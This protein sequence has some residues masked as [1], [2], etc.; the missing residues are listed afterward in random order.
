MWRGGYFPGERLYGIWY[1]LYAMKK[2][3][4][5]IPPL[6]QVNSPYP[7][8]TYLMGFLKQRGYPAENLKQIDLSLELVLKVF[9]STFLKLAFEE[10]ST[11]NRKARDPETSEELAFYLDAASDYCATID[12]VISFLQGRDPALAYRIASRTLLPE[13]PKFAANFE[14]LGLIG[15]RKAFG[16][17]GIQDQAKHFASLY[18]EDLTDFISKNVDERFLLSKYGEKL[19]ASVPSFDALHGALETKT[20]SLVDLALDS[21]VNE[22]IIGD[23]AF[24]P[25]V[26]GLSAPFPGNVYGAFRIARSL[27]QHWG[28]EVKLVLGGG[29]VNTELR[30]LTETKVFDYFDYVTLDDGEA[31]LLSI[32]SDAPLKRTFVKRSDAAGTPFVKYADESTLHDFPQKDV[33]APDYSGIDASRYLSLIEVLNPMHRLWSDGF[34]NK[35]TLAH[36]C[37]WKK[38]SF[39]DVTLDYIGRYD[40]NAADELIERMLKVSA[41][42]GCSG[43][44]FVDEAAPPKLLRDLSTR[45]IERGLGSRFTWWGNVRFDAFFTAEVAKTMANAGCI[46]ITGG[47][48]VA[49]DRLLKLMQKGTTVAQ[50]A[51]VAKAFREAGILV[52]AYL[53]YGFP[54]QTEQ[55]TID[56]LEIVRQLFQNDCLQ[57]AYWHRF[58]TTAHSPV[59]KA[60]EKFGVRILPEPETRFARNDLPF[61]DPTG[62]DHSAYA[63]GLKKAL[64][65]FM[66]G[67]G[68]EEN[69][70]FWFGFE[71]PAT[72]VARNF[73]RKAL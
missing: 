70:Q 2:A 9:S 3:L 65:N 33:G 43:F 1:W 55:E 41:Q 16:N 13:G 47:L 61:E 31:P 18:I 36:G 30:Q 15:L 21:L 17:L 35:L 62:C 46:A 22:K 14:N 56:A 42:T 20:P 60:P 23:L 51:K 25:E 27:K 26:V 54:S 72:T 19:A 69:L 73:V 12:N 40:A 39:C 11:A 10:V 53:M 67:V 52:H 68:L 48:E 28:E 49:S 6:S 34:W 29:Y 8:T 45:L 66:H 24:K 59:G 71:V 32:L 38:C 63:Y 57:S 64:Y 37:Y 5:V 58:S 50:V 4:F 44:H 7:A